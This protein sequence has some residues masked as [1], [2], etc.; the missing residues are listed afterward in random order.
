M[1]VCAERSV[2]GNYVSVCECRYW[3]CVCVCVFGPLVCLDHWLWVP[4]V[5]MLESLYVDAYDCDC[6]AR[7][8]IHITYMRDI[9]SNCECVYVCGH[10]VHTYDFR[11]DILAY[12]GKNLSTRPL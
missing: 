12:L 5:C 2:E 6:I 9:L 7:A 8:Y 4:R 11:V 3:V 10:Y 1:C